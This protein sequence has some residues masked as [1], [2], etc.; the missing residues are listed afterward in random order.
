[1]KTLT[2]LIFDVDGV[3]ADTESVNAG[4]SIQMF[5]DLFVSVLFEYFDIVAVYERGLF[6]ERFA[7]GLGCVIF[8]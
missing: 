6:L 4:A 3:I 1:M 8:N 2:G 7:L 5:A